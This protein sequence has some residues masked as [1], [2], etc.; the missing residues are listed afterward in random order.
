MVGNSGRS[1]RS[2]A[3][4]TPDRS[5]AMRKLTKFSKRKLLLGVGEWP[6][7][8]AQVCLAE[9]KAEHLKA[10]SALHEA[11]SSLDRTKV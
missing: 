10:F 4:S 6:H 9:D 3:K 1:I 2:A 7:H 5:L 11:C 8:P